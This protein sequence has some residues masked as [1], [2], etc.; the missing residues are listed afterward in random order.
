[1]VALKEELS[2]HQMERID[3]L[4]KM[5]SGL[6]T[7]ELDYFELYLSNKVKKTTGLHPM[8]LN[9]DWPSLKMDTEGTWPPTDP[10]WFKRQGGLSSL[11]G[12]GGG[13]A[14][15]DAGGEAVV[16]EEAPKEKTNYD[17]EL[18]GFEAKSK[19]KV[20]KELRAILGL[21]LKE[22]K[23]LVESSPCWI[24]KDVKKEDAEAL[25]EKMEKLGAT[26]NLA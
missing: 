20:I 12:T 2:E 13:A 10:N 19:I 16:E 25:K 9:M 5:T 11:A 17:I 6:D 14:Q 22:A 8:K 15:A 23:E 4:A 24:Q 21:G 18:A 3:L 26:I 1:M 7:Y